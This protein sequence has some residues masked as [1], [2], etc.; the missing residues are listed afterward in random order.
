[1][2]VALIRARLD[3]EQ[4]WAVG[5]VPSAAEEIHLPVVADPRGGAHRPYLPG[6]GLAGALRRHLGPLATDWLGPEP[7]AWE[8]TQAR[9]GPRERKAGRLVLLG[10]HVEATGD[11]ARVEQ[12]GVTSICGSRR[13]AARGG[14]RQEE[15]NRPTTVTIAMT[16]ELEEHERETDGALLDALASWAP[17]VGRASSTGMGSARVSLVEHLTVDLTDGAQLTWWLTERDSWL[18]RADAGEPPVSVPAPRQGTAESRHGTPWSIQWSVRE[19][20]HVGAGSASESVTSSGRAEVQPTMT[21]DGKPVVPG[22]S[23]KGVVRGRVQAILALLDVQRS[24]EVLDHLFG[25]SQSGHGLLAFEDSVIELD[26]IPGGAL[27]NR[28]HVAIDRFTG[29]AR[30]TGLFVVEGIPAGTPVTLT[31][32]SEG[33][34]PG[35]VRNLLMHVFWDIHDGIIGVGGM[36]TRGYGGLEFPHGPN[37]P[38]PA[39]PEPINVAA[40]VTLLDQPAQSDEGSN[41]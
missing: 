34:L 29:G 5:R 16:Y 36:V 21:V 24:G 3:I 30:D 1:M 17:S 14:F 10:T 37:D 7:P 32:R 2:R 39:R 18:R 6:T 33:K 40:L 8:E 31:I 23:W 9:T 15:W 13:A 41:G 12:R 27:R 38:V 28:T 11:E 25:S 22:S 19:P 26:S 20:L 4:R 35:P